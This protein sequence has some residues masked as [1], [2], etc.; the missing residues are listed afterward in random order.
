MTHKITI[1]NTFHNTETFTRVDD[2][3]EITGARVA[4][5]RGRLCSL[6]CQCGGGDLKEYGAGCIV[7]EDGDAMIF[8]GDTYAGGRFEHI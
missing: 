7:D 6:G 1:K 3:Y 4:A 2:D 5:I 8:Y